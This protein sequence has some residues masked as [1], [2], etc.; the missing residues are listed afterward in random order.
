MTSKAISTHIKNSLAVFALDLNQIK[1]C[2]AHFHSLKILQATEC[3]DI[4]KMVVGFRMLYGLSFLKGL[5][6]L[7]QAFLNFFQKRGY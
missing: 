2:V 7:L 1:I 4:K 3:R 5:K 6:L